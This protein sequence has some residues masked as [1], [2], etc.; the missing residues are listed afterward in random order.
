MAIPEPQVAATIRSDEA[1]D[2]RWDVVVI[3]AGPAGAMAARQ[4]ALEDA[5]VLL[6]DRASF[7]RSKV[8]GCCVNGAAI[9]VLAQ[10]GLG[11]LLQR[12]H[13][14]KVEA[15]QLASSGRFATVP[16]SEG[17]SLSRE[18]LDTALIQAAIEAG[19]EF[20]DRALALIGERT[21]DA[22]EIL[23]K[24][25]SGERSAS[26]MAVV[27]A[28]GLGCRVFA[29]SESDDRKASPSSRVGAGTI[30]D[31]APAEYTAGTIYMACHPQ[32]YVG[33]VRLEDNRLDVAA[34]LNANAI[35]ESG[36]VAELVGR[37]LTDSKLPIPEL[38]DGA[39]WHGTGRLTQRREHVV[40]ERCFFIGDAAGYVE[41]FTGE[42]IAWALA[43]GRVVAP[44]VLDFVRNDPN[45]NAM[46]AWTSTHQKL[47]ANRAR[48]CRC[49]SR[50]LRYP[51]LVNIAVRLLALAPLLARPV[52]RSLNASFE[53]KMPNKETATKHR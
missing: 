9:G 43:S 19:A 23:L 44:I 7:P 11:D 28:G 16:L 17:V 10:V 51:T 39:E 30:L 37:I 13:A 48:L 2:K 18:R 22:C 26:A 53:A 3:G 40:S 33:L 46:H 42:G 1:G 32:G 52:V 12:C 14:R 45:S 8:C 20:L 24:T 29:E 6:V 4:L 47:I 21:S 35:K 5:R 31:S 41:P 38:L 49:V 27:V 34:A 15:F 36:G 50:L 25:E